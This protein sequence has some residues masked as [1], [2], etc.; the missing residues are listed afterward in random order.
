[1]GSAA[2]SR[3]AWFVTNPIDSLAEAVLALKRDP[4]RPVRAQ[5]DDLTVEIRTVAA[6]SALP[7]SAG[8]AF[9]RARWQGEESLDELLDFFGCARRE[10]GSRH[11][12]D[13]WKFVLDTNIVI[14]AM[15]GDSRVLD[16]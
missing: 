9:R 8:D 7:R 4:T 16:R 2:T 12:A 13:L 1:M 10:G 14:A 6:A 15:H 5:V 3:Y 11:V